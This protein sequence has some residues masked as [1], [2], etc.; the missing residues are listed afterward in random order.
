[1]KRLSILFA[2]TAPLFGQA[3]DFK[4]LDKFDSLASNKT[5]VTLDSSM[6]GLAA[7]LLGGA[8]DKDTDSIASLVKGLKGIYVR[9]YEFDKDGQYSP[10]DIEPFRAY[11]KQLQWNKIIESQEGKDLSEVYVQPAANG[12]FGGVAIVAIEPRELTVVYINGDLSL[13]DLQKLQGNVGI[14]DLDLKGARKPTPPVPPPP[15][16]QKKEDGDHQDDK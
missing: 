3:F 12:R 15:P 5:K 8:G 13:N 7:G 2:L 6:L 14:P 4:S 11:L 10:A 9:N 1:V 16:A